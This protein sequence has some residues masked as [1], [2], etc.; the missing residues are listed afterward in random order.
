MLVQQLKEDSSIKEPQ[1]FYCYSCCRHLNLKCSCLK[2]DSNGPVVIVLVILKS[3]KQDPEF[4]HCVVS[5]CASGQE[6]LRM[7]LRYDILFRLARLLQFR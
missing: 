7:S 5:D 3:L 4:P 6:I 2:L 1:L